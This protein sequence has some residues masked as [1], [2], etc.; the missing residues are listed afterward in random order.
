MTQNSK[1]LLDKLINSYKQTGKNYF[2]PLSILGCS[3]SCINELEELG[4]INVNNDIIGS[5]SLTPFA[6]NQ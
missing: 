3:Q 5:F 1:D 4:Y 2:D 6:L